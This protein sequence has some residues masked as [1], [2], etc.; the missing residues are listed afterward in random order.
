MIEELKAQVSTL[1][2][3]KKM[4]EHSLKNALL[5]KDMKENQKKPEKKLETKTSQQ[6]ES[7]Y[8]SLP[9]KSLNIG[10]KIGIENV[11][12]DLSL[13]KHNEIENINDENDYSAHARQP[14]QNQTF[15]GMPNK[16]EKSSEKHLKQRSINLG[17]INKLLNEGGDVMEMFELSSEIEE[18]FPDKVAPPRL[19]DKSLKERI[20]MNQFKLDF[21]RIG[22]PRKIE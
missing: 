14:P 12:N 7:S 6:T 16:Y 15:V 3:E 17:Q 21:T 1:T 5:Q 20:D 18:A 13:K 8:L 2:S 10:S 11:K 4:A 22:K 9:L 19:K